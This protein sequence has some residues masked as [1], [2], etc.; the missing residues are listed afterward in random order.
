M[1]HRTEIPG[2]GAGRSAIPAGS[3]AVTI[4]LFGAVSVLIAALAVACGDEDRNTVAGPSLDQVASPVSPVFGRADHTRTV[5]V[6]ATDRYE[7]QGLDATLAYYGSE[8]SIEGQWYVFIVDENDLVI[9]HPDPN[10]LG[11]D[12]KGWVGTDA[13][14]YEFGSQMLS[15]DEDGTWVS[16][17]YKN[18][19]NVSIGSADFGD[20]ELK[21]AWVVRRD[22]LL[23]GSGWYV[24][25]DELT[26][27]FVSTAVSK[28]RSGGLEAVIE[29]FSG[30]E[31][32]FSGL[33][34]AIDY[35]NSAETVEGDWFAFIAD[36]NGIIID[37][38]DKDL[39]GRNLKDL[40]DTDTFETTEEG[41][42]VTTESMRVWVVRHDGMTFASG[43]HGDH[44][45]S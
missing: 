12:L 31:S 24:E 5:V 6:D 13:N 45:A 8:E 16:Y 29:Y 37:H 39:V 11:L 4:G 35:Y 41:N 15:V 10:R 2:K 1:K 30:P 14:G 27:T 28:F 42:W 33:A 17:V 36:S 25:A 43:W 18:P 38:Y 22:G 44:D 26:K 7:S 34:S 20:V 23:F 19:E 40:L 3:L 9:A 32:V 21:N